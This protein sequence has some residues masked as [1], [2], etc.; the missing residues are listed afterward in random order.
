MKTTYKPLVS[1]L[2]QRQQVRRPLAVAVSAACGVVGSMSINAPALAQSLEEVLVT[3]TRRAESVQ[4]IPMSVSVMGEAQLTD[5]NVTDMEDYL[6]MLPN[7]GFI[8]TGPSTANIYIRG[9]SSG[10]ESLLGANPAVA[11]YLDEQPVTLVGAYLNPHIYDINRIEVLAG[12]QGTTFG[13]N[14]QSGAIRIMTNQPEIG[15]FS[16][17]Y[18]ID[19]SQPK[20]GDMSYRAEGFVNIPMG[21]RSALRVM[22]FYKRDGG[23]IDNVL[24]GHTFSRSNIRAGLPEDSPLRAIAADVT[25]TNEDVV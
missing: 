16:G 8:S 24:G 22:G 17:G 25:V 12:P 4:D 3:A 10:G 20:S 9:I 14:A 23:Y 13:A 11:V 21:E 19:G 1:P 2:L 18:A 6:M 15:E 7:V 5:L